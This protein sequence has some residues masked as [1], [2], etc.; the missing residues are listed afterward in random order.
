M[1]CACAVALPCS[2]VG[3]CSMWLINLYSLMIM[4]WY[5]LS[6][7]TLLL[8][9]QVWLLQISS[10]HTLRRI[11]ISGKANNIISLKSQLLKQHITHTKQNTI[12]KTL[13]C[14][15]CNSVIP[16]WWI[17]CMFIRPQFYGHTPRFVCPASSVERG[18]GC[19]FVLHVMGV[20]NA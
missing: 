15:L 3:W 8:Q 2:L 14:L 1:V 6:S 9:L 10:I 5:I 17:R 11:V 12:V 13:L 18:N 19:V 4:S 16:K 20:M 7:S